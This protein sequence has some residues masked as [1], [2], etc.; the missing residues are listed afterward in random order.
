MFAKISIECELIKVEN[1]CIELFGGDLTAEEYAAE[2]LA[3][4]FLP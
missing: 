1:L 2:T 4:L 3:I